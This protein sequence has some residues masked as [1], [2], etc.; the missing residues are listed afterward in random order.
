MQLIQAVFRNSVA[1]IAEGSSSASSVHDR[2]VSVAEGK[3]WFVVSISSRGS[4]VGMATGCRLNSRGSMPDKG[5]GF[6]CSV[7]I[8]SG[9]H[10][11]SLSSGY[12]G[13]LPWGKLPGR[14]AVHSLHRVLRSHECLSYTATPHPHVSSWCDI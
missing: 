1:V 6:L 7:H 8:G 4:V 9:A 12:R 3:N 5:N 14:E 2:P 10:S 13:L 11:S